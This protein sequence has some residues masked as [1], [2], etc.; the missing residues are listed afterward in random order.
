MEKRERDTVFNVPLENVND[1]V[2]TLM[3]KEKEQP[4]GYGSFIEKRD[5]RETKKTLF[6]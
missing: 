1:A 6:R 5:A 4:N 3:K 2:D